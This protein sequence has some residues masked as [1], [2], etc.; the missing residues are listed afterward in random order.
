MIRKEIDEL[1]KKQLEETNYLYSTNLQRKIFNPPNEEIHDFLCFWSDLLGFGNDLFKN[2]WDLGLDGFK[3]IRNRLLDA[4]NML[5][6]NIDINHN[7]KG[8]ILNDGIC[9]IMRCDYNIKEIDY[10]S[11]LTKLGLYFLSCVKTHIAINIIEKENKYPGT[12]S[13][14]AYGK[15]IKYLTDQITFDDF[16]FN[17]TKP[18]PEGIST[19]AR[20][21]GNPI[22]LYNPSELQM[23]TAFSKSYILESLGSDYGICGNE[24]YIDK[25]VFDFISEYIK[26][27]HTNAHF[28][29]KDD[30]YQYLV[31]YELDDINKVY[32]GFKLSKKTVEIDYKDWKTTVYK[33]IAFYPHD[34]PIDEFEFDLYDYKENVWVTY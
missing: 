20:E 31:P 11:W 22:K 24:L 6:S 16:V 19:V 27:S 15:G 29:E 25:S 1:R 2:N 28:I 21:I 14:L 26:M 4:H 32:F 13:V 10:I 5:I 34:E 9:Q 8:L 33:V 23:N 30:C 17:Y 3:K 7:T 12:R 18:D